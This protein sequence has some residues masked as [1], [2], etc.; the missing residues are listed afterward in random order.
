[1]AGNSTVDTKPHSL[2]LHEA[3]PHARSAPQPT[4]PQPTFENAAASGFQFPFS[5][6]F[7]YSNP[8]MMP[9]MPMP[10]FYNQGLGQ[11]P[12]GSHPFLGPQYPPIPQAT[13]SCRQVEYPE[14]TRWFRFLDEH[15]E[16]RKDGIS[17]APFGDMLKNKGFVRITQLTL[18]FIT[19][20]DLQDWLGIEVGTAILIMQY[21]KDDIESIKAGK[22]VIPS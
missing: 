5:S 17:F 11:N 13:N 3:R 8:F 12:I 20:K 19:L 22:L 16:R 9:P 7:N 15:E 6:G 1:M 14:V 21:A 2:H 10:M 18:D 4:G